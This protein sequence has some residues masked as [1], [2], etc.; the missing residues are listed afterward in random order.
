MALP[1]RKSYEE[2][3]FPYEEQPQNAYRYKIRN[4]QKQG[5]GVLVS[6]VGD[7]PRLLSSANPTLREREGRINAKATAANAE[8]LNHAH[9]AHTKSITLARLKQQFNKKQLL[10]RGTKKLL[11][12]TRATT[13]SISIVAWGMTLWFVQVSFALISNIYMGVIGAGDTLVN[14]NAV[15]RIAGWVVNQAVEGGTW[16][17]TGTSISLGDMS[18]GIFIWLWMVSFALGM[19]TLFGASLQFMLS[20][21][22]SLSGDNTSMKYIAFIVVIF[23]YSVPLLNLL[24]WFLVYVAVV[25]KYPK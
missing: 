8:T 16:L 12:R 6:D 2:E 7:D 14:S 24:P 5:R 18:A 10:L 22:N 3:Q 4:A 13:V 23:G 21:I 20:L 15:T 17:I 9:T 19:V 11:R 25:W 1:Q